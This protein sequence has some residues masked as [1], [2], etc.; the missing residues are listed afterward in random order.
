LID[1]TLGHAGRGA[2]GGALQDDRGVDINLLIDKAAGTTRTPA[3]GHHR[4]THS[5]FTAGFRRGA[6]CAH[7]FAVADEQA[8]PIS[9]IS[10]RRA[11]G[12]LVACTPARIEKETFE[13][14]ELQSSN[15]H[16]SHIPPSDRRS[17]ISRNHVFATR[18]SI[19]DP[20]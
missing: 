12:R 18:R 10:R 20:C 11:E 6:A 1:K 13:D 19:E 5:D 14:A 7:L 9:L 3:V 2:S 8:S 4:A 15:I 16:R 17:E